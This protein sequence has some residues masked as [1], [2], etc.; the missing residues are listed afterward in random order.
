MTE[1]TTN[2]DATVEDEVAPV[3]PDDAAAKVTCPKVTCPVCGRTYRPGDVIKP[4]YLP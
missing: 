2:A 4:H 1:N 3:E